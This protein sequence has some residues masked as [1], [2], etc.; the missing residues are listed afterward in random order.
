[1]AFA[2]G[3]FITAQRLNRLQPKVYWAQ[4]SGTFPV[5]QSLVDIPG[6]AM[7]VIVET[8]GATISI[9]WSVSVYA[10]ASMLASSSASARAWFGS[11]SSPVYALAQLTANAEKVT[12]ANSWMTTAP[13]AATYTAKLVGSTPAQATMSNYGSIKVTVYEVA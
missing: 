3:Q 9:D 7:S 8:A 12:I 2:P 13:T 10:N 11:D 5:S 6:A 4:A 1:M